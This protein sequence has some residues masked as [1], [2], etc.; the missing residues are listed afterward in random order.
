MRIFAVMMMLL[1]ITSCATNRKKAIAL[2]EKGHHEE[3]IQYWELALKDDKDDAEALAGLRVSQAAV[4]NDRLVKVRD[5]RTSMNH[6]SALKFLKELVETQQKWNIQTDFNTSTFQRQETLA[7]WKF[8][9][10]QLSLMIEKGQPLAAAASLAEYRPIFSHYKANEQAEHHKKIMKVGK[11][12]CSN[13]MK[14][15]KGSPYYESFARQYCH[16]FGKNM[17]SSVA[18]DKNLIS[19]IEPTIEIAGIPDE[20]KDVVLTRVEK[21]LSLTPWY[22][23]QGSKVLPLKLKGSFT[24][25]LEKQDVKL[26]HDYEVEEAYTVYKDVK[27][28]RVDPNTKELISYTESEAVTKYQTVTRE[29]EYTALKKTQTYH[30]KLSGEFKINNKTHQFELT[31]S[32]VESVIL[33]DQDRPSIGLTPSRKDVTDPLEK[34]KTYADQTSELFKQKSVEIWADSYCILPEKRSNQAIAENVFRCRKIYTDKNKEFV[35]QWF[36]QQ[37]GV[38]SL[39]AE[40]TLGTF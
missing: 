24:H 9:Q 37:H 34:F 15:A 32:D 38:D 3:A 33:H 19:R 12:H 21:Q 14:M 6:A 16:F 17:K 4:I 18:L 36:L 39:V 8:H 25:N 1:M 35:D 31:K 11:S 20:M 5:L 23:L 30:F 13:V 22:S 2:S 28:T 10:D 7:L 26:I 27:K 29:F 40:R